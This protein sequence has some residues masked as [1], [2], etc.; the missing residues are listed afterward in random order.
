[1]FRLGEP[2]SLTGFK[3]RNRAAFISFLPSP[4]LRR[5][6]RSPVG[7]R[8]RPSR[9]TWRLLKRAAPTGSANAHAHPATHAKD[10]SR[11]S[12]FCDAPCS[13][14]QGSNSTQRRSFCRPSKLRP[15]GGCLMAGTSEPSGG[16]KRGAAR[17]QAREAGYRETKRSRQNRSSELKPALPRER[18]RFGVLSS[19]LRAGEEP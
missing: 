5:G 6:C 14:V 3:L 4:P 12:S 2:Q 7:P 18:R 13:R 9:R 10:R 17:T 11:P 8:P 19:K 16:A 1:M 15:T